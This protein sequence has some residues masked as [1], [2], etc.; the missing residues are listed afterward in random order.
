VC[1]G[2]AKAPDIGSA[3][4]GSG[5]GA[6]KVV[7]PLAGAP[8]GEA[9]GPARG[10]SPGLPLARPPRR[11][12]NDPLFWLAIAA[13][14]AVWI[15]LR[16]S[17]GAGLM[18][19]WPPAPWVASPWGFVLAMA[20]YP[21]LEE[22]VFRGGLQPWIAGKLA[23]APKPAIAANILTSIAFAAAHL[24]AHT[25]AWALATFF[26]SLVFGF[27]RD[28]HGGLPTPIALHVFYNAGYFSFAG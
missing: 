17:S 11:A 8:A 12:G 16:A 10:D 3:D 13:G 19:T 7:A 20:V 18:P 21:V 27:F 26:P 28:R 1:A 4:A 9:A 6:A 22:I 24:Y 14:P 2:R 23:R 5:P 25:P 15:A